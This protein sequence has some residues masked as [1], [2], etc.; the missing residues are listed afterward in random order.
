MFL[1]KV[2][3]VFFFFKLQLFNILLGDES[4]INIYFC[5][6]VVLL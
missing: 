4:N 6:Q 3:F 1:L 5:Y 2:L